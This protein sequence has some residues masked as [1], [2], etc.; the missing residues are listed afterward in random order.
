MCHRK[1]ALPNLKLLKFPIAYMEHEEA[2]LLGALGDGYVDIKRNELQIYQKNLEWLEYMNSLLRQIFGIEGRIFKRDV[3]WLRKR[4]K[5]MVLRILELKKEV[6]E[7]EGFVA[8]LFDSEGSI[9]L[10]TSKIPVIDI[11]QS[12]KGLAQLLAAQR[13]LT[14]VG[15]ESRMNGPY[16]NK[17]GKLLQ[18]HLR[19]YGAKRCRAFL[20]AIG[21]KHPDKLARFKQYL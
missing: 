3:F 20:K 16:V 10:S 6:L 7:S 14:R 5:L 8:G 19:V 2:Y 18:Y 12:E 13:I 9:Y 1:S 11:T 4:N 17:H 21:S 15:I